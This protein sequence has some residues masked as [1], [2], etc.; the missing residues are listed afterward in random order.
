MIQEC[1]MD[2]FF[3][4]V[5]SIPTKLPAEWHCLKHY[6]HHDQEIQQQP[7]S[8]LLTTFIIDLSQS[9]QKQSV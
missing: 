2:T 4:L 7:L 5:K 1:Y 9:E 3:F 6:K 8:G